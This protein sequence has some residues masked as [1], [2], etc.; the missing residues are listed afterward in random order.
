MSSRISITLEGS[1]KLKK[2]LLDKAQMTAVKRIVS[3]HGDL[4]NNRMKRQTTVS[5]I[6]GYST[7]DTAGSINTSFASDGLSVSVGATTLYAPYVEYG[8]RYMDAEPFVRP[9]FDVQKSAFIADLK[10][11]M[12]G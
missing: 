7:G 3:K 6:K 9:V 10:S 1:A 8:T 12:G 4:L 5:Y 11:L 2:A